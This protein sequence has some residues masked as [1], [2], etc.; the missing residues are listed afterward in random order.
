[1]V[2]K[3]LGGHAHGARLLRER[4]PSEAS[5]KRVSG[6]GRKLGEQHCLMSSVTEMA[7]PSQQHG[8]VRA[9]GGCDDLRVAHRAAGLDDGSHARFRGSL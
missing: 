6:V 9:V 2:D 8:N 4:R 1:M 5:A 7:A 3:Q